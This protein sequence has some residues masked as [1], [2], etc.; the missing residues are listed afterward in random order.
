MIGTYSFQRVNYVVM[1]IIMTPYLLILF[2]LLGVKFI[3]I[4]EERIL[5]T[6]IGCAIG[7]LASYLLFPSWESGQLK[8]N[9]IKVIKANLCYLQKLADLIAGKPVRITDYKLARKDVYVNS[10]NLAA[11][12]QRMLSEP[13]SKQQNSRELHKFVVLNHILSS[14]IATL[15][16]EMLSV[17]GSRVYPA[18]YLRL[19]RRSE[20][21]LGGSLKKLD[22]GYIVPAS[23]ISVVENKIPGSAEKGN[24]DDELLK[25]QLDFIQKLSNDIDQVTK[26]IAHLPETA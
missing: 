7:F 11:A 12:F 2:R 10:A 3:G 21:V 18:A 22:P 15:T 20:S 9:M 4:A 5:D 25:E 23:G 16:S 26:V 19:A 24:P 8:N 17:Q 6:L 14:N 13:K 1:V